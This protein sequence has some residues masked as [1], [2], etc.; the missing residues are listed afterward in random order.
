MRR[1]GNDHVEAFFRED[2]VIAGVVDHDLNARVLEDASVERIE[3]ARRFDDRRLDFQGDKLRE[4]M[5]RDGAGRD[6]GTVPDRDDLLCLR[7][8]EHREMADKQ[9]RLHVAGGGSI[10]LAVDRQGEMRVLRQGR[11]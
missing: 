3:E 2:E 9:L 7:R 10:R 8:Q 11:C 5:G 1:L 6:P 4:G